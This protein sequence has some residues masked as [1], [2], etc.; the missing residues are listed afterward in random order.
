MQFALSLDPLLCTSEILG[1]QACTTMPVLWLLI[2]RFG[3]QRTGSQLCCCLLYKL[4]PPFVM[5][6][7]TMVLPTYAHKNK[8]ADLV[9]ALTHCLLSVHSPFSFFKVVA[10]L[11]F[12]KEILM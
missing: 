4:K 10:Y 8:Q 2:A 5:K 3:Y 9:P 1:L 7:G 6:I 11:E 12:G